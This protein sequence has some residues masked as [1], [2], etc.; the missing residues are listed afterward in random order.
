[1]LRVY[2]DPVEIIS[3]VGAGRRAVAGI[4][5]ELAIARERADELVARD[6]IAGVEWHPDRRPARFVEQLERDVDFILAEGPRRL[7]D[8]PQPPTMSPM[9]TAESK[10]RHRR[11][12]PPPAKSSSG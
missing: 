10:R 9:E 3:P 12:V 11:H 2:G 5:G 1:M 8:L 6:A 7:E 4:A